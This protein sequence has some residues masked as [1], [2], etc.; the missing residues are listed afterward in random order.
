VK[1]IPNEPVVAVLGVVVAVL[2]VLMVGVV[3]GV[4]VAVVAVEAA[5]VVP[6][7]STGVLNVD[8]DAVVNAVGV[9]VLSAKHTCAHLSKWRRGVAVECGTCD[10]GRRLESQ[11]GTTA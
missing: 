9:M 7:V 2:T 11:P 6:L 3:N 4:V 10:Q 5:R 8:S 1:I